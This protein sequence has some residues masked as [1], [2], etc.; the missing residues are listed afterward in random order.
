LYEASGKSSALNHL[1]SAHKTNPHKLY[2]ASGQSSALKNL[3]KYLQNLEA[4]GHIGFFKMYE[5]SGQSSALKNLGKYL[6]N[7]EASGQI[8]FFKMYEASGQSSA[9]KNLGKYIHNLEA[10]GQARVHPQN[11]YIQNVRSE[12]PIFCI[13]KFEQVPTKLGSEWPSEGSSPELVYN[14]L[15]RL[16]NCNTIDLPI[17]KVCWRR[18]RE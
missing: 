9:L 11:L 15:I 16:F 1:G 7:L 10:S 5:A 6:Q 18:L 12:W 4:I 13:E 2:E 14:I 8:G 17:R 3:G